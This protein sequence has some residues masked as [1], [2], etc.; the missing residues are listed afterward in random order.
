M[1]SWTMSECGK[2]FVIVPMLL[3]CWLKPSHVRK[4]YLAGVTQE[5]SARVQVELAPVDAIVFAFG[6]L[7]KCN[8]LISAFELNKHD[9]STFHDQILETR[10]WALLL[11]NAATDPTG[12]SNKGKRPTNKR[13]KRLSADP[14]LTTTCD[15]IKASGTALSGQPLDRLNEI[16]E[17]ADHNAKLSTLPNFHIGIYFQRLM[18]KY[19]VVWN[20]N[21][22]F[23]EDKHRFFK[24]IVL[25]TNHQKPERQLLVKEAISHTI[26]A[27]L[28]GA[29]AHTHADVTSQL[30]R[31]D[32]HCPSF[33]NKY[34]SPIEIEA[35]VDA[36]ADADANVDTFDDVDKAI[37][38]MAHHIKPDAC[39]R[40]KMAYL[41][42]AQLSSKLSEVHHDGFHELMRP[43]MDAYGLKASYW[44][45]E[46]LYWY[47]QCSYTSAA[48][49]KRE[50]VH[51]G[52][53]IKLTSGELALVRQIYT[54]AF[55]YERV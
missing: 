46:P 27:A 11:I 15:D 24:K 19:G 1:R 53:Y 16:G 33:F 55:K 32:R 45:K 50:T 10:R 49:H 25:C 22:L 8:S 28:E 54:H 12:R 18:E 43:A 6:R 40:L 41:R 44:G 52:G 39:G 30:Y 29:F 3:R 31:L 38:A 14:A 36:D 34:V 4:S 5:L 48:T 35:N 9:C 51:I 2:A 13:R 42:R 47:E 17:N 26:K 37:A 7:A 20:T 21:V 23:G